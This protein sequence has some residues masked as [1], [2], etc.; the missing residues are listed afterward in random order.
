MVRDNKGLVALCLM[1]AVVIFLVD[2]FIP[3]GVA[4]GV[5]YVSVVL[6]SL[7]SPKR[8]LTLY[9]TVL[10]SVL[11]VLGYFTSPSGGELWKVLSNRALAEAIIWAAALLGLALKKGETGIA[12]AETYLRDAEPE[13]TSPRL[14]LLCLFLA[15]LIFV[16]DLFL[17][18]GV[19]GGVPYVAV[20]L[21]SLW[22]PQRSFTLYI[23]ILCSALTIAGYTQSPV[24]GEHW[25]VLSNRFLAEMVIW[26]STV[27][28]LGRKSAEA[29]LRAAHDT[30]EGRVE[31]RTSDLRAEVAERKRVEKELQLTQFTLDHAPDAVYWME[32]TGRFIYV[33][34]TA[35]RTLGYTREELLS[36]GVADIDLNLPD[37]VPPEMQ[38][39]TKKAGS[40][41]LETEHRTKDGRLIPVDVMVSFIEYDGKE[42]HCSFTRDI[43]ERRK[44]EA[45]LEEQLHFSQTLIDTIPSPIFYKDAEGRYLGCNV[46]FEKSIGLSK[47]EV[48]GKSVY[49]LAPKEL[50]D[51]YFEADSVLFNNPGIQFYEAKV[52]YTDGRE[53]DILF[54]KATFTR[55]DGTMAGLVGVMTDVTEHKRAEEALRES[56]G[57]LQSVLENTTAVIYVK[58]L[59]G[60]HLIVN[61]RFEELFGVD[62]ESIKGKT[63]YDFMPKKEADIC[64]AND[65]RVIDSG[66]VLEEE[67]TLPLS[68]G[69]HTYLSVKFPLLDA[70]GELYATCGISTDI[71]ERKKVEEAL[72]IEKDF[73]D[74]AINTQSDTLFVFDTATGKA[75]RWNRAFS[76]VSGY[77]DEEIGAMK[78]P[79]SYYSDEDLQKAASY[80]ESLQEKGAA[81]IELDLLTKDGNNIPTEYSASLIK[82]D[83]DEPIQVISI[84]RDITERKKAEEELDHSRRML[85]T[86]LDTI[87]V[88]VFWKDLNLNYLGCNTA[89]AR[90][91]GLDSPEKII[92][93]DD[94]G[95]A[96]SKEAKTYRADD[97]KVIES[98]E[99]KLNYEEQQ[100]SPTGEALWLRTSKVPLKNGVG[101]II[102]VLGTYEDITERKKVEEQNRKLS[103]AVEQSLECVV[104][105]DTE[106]TIE[107]VNPYF[108]ELTGYTFDE[109][110]GLN[111]RVL[112]SDKQDGA[113]YEEL[114]CTIKSGKVWRGQFL[115]KK[116]SGELYWENAT[117]SPIR[118]E[119]GTLTHF[120]AVKED[121][122]ERMRAESKLREKSEKL[123][124]ANKDL[125]ELTMEITRIEETEKKRFAELLHDDIGQN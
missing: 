93:R 101:E 17:P 16:I 118:D 19:A 71:T 48:E 65:W 81:T 11:V 113:F 96:W 66:K 61:R 55:A 18:L 87:P 104:I 5:P 38:E 54:N 121:I 21:I 119:S 52:K 20:I 69:L 9:I 35:C 30:L 105:T 92:G 42:Y 117:I 75:L 85:L 68:D 2:S 97:T 76:E 47:S 31:E 57:R 41:R 10:C 109:A 60:C 39:A 12:L 27:L 112:K 49:D 43:T 107:Y 6:I 62:R 50:A 77:S 46:A 67:E 116:K 70:E 59:E 80:L 95:L 29:M 24:G 88:R 78:A 90:D 51:K 98:G 86:V 99:V 34:E 15:A 25:K 8:S 22:S 28:G 100:S 79:D 124:M 3:L 44:A 122:T 82:N 102:G 108:T 84:G 33:N 125:H 72:R 13:K 58:D 115:N 123:D 1:L 74:S 53:H 26:T 23:A 120:V 64:T 4:G 83:V 37:G 32:P 106:G 63:V 111:P 56:E 40:G 73:I 110:V 103:Q 91:G 14:I 36:M 7:W 114:W 94:Y 45:A 89:F